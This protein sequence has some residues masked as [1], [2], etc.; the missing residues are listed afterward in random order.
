MSILFKLIEPKVYSR[1][2]TENA[3]IKLLYEVE[4]SHFGKLGLH[5]KLKTIQEL[6]HSLP[7][8]LVRKIALD[9][10]IRI[11]TYTAATCRLAFET[12]QDTD[13][14]KDYF[15][16]DPN[17]VVRA[18]LWLN[19]S[20]GPINYN[21]PFS[22]ERNPSLLQNIFEQEP[23]SRL[24]ALLLKRDTWTDVIYLHLADYSQQYIKIE[25]KKQAFLLIDAFAN[26]EN[27][28]YL[29]KAFDS[30]EDQL[31]H[32][33]LPWA[34]TEHDYVVTHALEYLNFNHT[35][36]AQ[37]IDALPPEKRPKD[38]LDAIQSHNAKSFSLEMD[39]QNS[40]TKGSLF[41]RLFNSSKDTVK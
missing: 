25:R 20:T 1:M 32:N 39:E 36:K 37:L 29:F 21:L 19:K 3:L 35:S 15:E 11:R 9:D 5:D 31:V 28:N 6:N 17:E 41:A 23:L 18:C 30:F 14:I 27:F 40:K 4:S 26:S 33:L 34:K 7:R 12:R 22:L 10:D 38:E 13:S 16:N 8:S 2:S 24:T